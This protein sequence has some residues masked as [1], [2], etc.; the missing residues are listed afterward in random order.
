MTQDELLIYPRSDLLPVNPTHQ[1]CHFVPSII[2]A[3]VMSLSP[4]IDEIRLYVQDHDPDIMYLT[5]TWLKD[6]V[7]SSVIH[8]MNYTLVRKDR[9]YAQHGAEYAC[10]LKNLYR[11]QFFGNTKEIYQSRFYGASYV[12]DDYPA[13]FLM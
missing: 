6:T 3:N 8:I 7:E 9:I 4:Q 13:V 2:L 1:L 5:E 11:L 10:I 12:P